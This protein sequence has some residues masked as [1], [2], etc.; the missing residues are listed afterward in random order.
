M[1]YLGII[2][3][4]VIFTSCKIGAEIV[5]AEDQVEESAETV[6][7]LKVVGLV[8]ISETGCPF[9]IEALTEDGT[10]KMY[11]INLD[12]KFKVNGL[13]LKFEY[14]VVKASQPAEC[15]TD[16]AVELIDPTAYRK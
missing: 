16:I 4:S 9:F 1:K 5:D 7:D 3:L 11:P 15:D 14:H 6:E 13:K 10:L 8:H 12:D 2:A